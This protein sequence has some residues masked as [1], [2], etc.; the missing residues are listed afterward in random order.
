MSGING[1]AKDLRVDGEKILKPMQ[2]D[3][4]SLK[5]E[6]RK[7]RALKLITSIGKRGIEYDVFKNALESLKEQQKSMRILSR[8]F[9]KMQRKLTPEE[10]IVLNE[11][12]YLLS[13]LQERRKEYFEGSL[14]DIKHLRGSE[15]TMLNLQIAFRYEQVQ[16]IEKEIT[17][18]LKKIKR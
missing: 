11:S 10:S 7:Y 2:M 14:E 1:E 12:F 8:R 5:H 16:E 4:H 18:R 9:K 15:P 13:E 3:C 17:K 6:K